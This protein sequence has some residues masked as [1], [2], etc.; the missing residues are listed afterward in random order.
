MF[1]KIM[2]SIRVS[3]LIMLGLSAVSLIAQNS[4]MPPQPPSGER[5]GSERREFQG[6]SGTITAINKD[7]FVIKTEDGRTVTIKTTSDTIYRRERLEAKRS[8]FRVGENIMAGGQASGADTYTAR[9]VGT[10]PAGMRM[11]GPGPMVNSADMGKKFIVGEVTKIDGTRLTIM[12]PDK[13]EQVIE[14]DDDTSFR[15]AKRESVTLADVKVGDRVMGRGDLK[16]GTFFPKDLN[17]GLPERGMRPHGANPNA[18]GNV[19]TPH[20]QDNNQQAK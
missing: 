20:Q 3:V 15:N 10:R 8:D 16:N 2:K 7:S 5:S 11:G 4:G 19:P 1:M 18:N 6:T 17:V 13:I 9:F 12:R 14:V